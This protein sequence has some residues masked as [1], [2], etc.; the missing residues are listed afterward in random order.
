[1]GIPEEEEKEKETK[2]LFFKKMADKFPNLWREME[3]M[4]LKSHQIA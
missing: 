2:I 1:M 3:F 4:K